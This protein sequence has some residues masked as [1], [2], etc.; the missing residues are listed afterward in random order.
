VVAATTRMLSLKGAFSPVKPVLPAGNR[1]YQ[2]LPLAIRLQGDLS[3]D[4]MQLK[5]GALY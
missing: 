3:N 5:R 4:Q 2:E 1:L